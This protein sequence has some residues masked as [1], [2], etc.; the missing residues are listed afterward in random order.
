MERNPKETEQYQNNAETDSKVHREQATAH[1]QGLVKA[2][3][4]IHEYEYKE[5]DRAHSHIKDLGAPAEESVR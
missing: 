4:F 2:E 3:G 1:I 5:K